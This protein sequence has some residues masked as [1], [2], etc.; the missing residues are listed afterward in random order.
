MAGKIIAGVAGVLIGAAAVGVAWATTPH[1]YIACSLKGGGIMAMD[2]IEKVER[3]R[4]HLEVS[5]KGFPK[6]YRQPLSNISMCL[7]GGT[8]MINA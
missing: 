8:A 6:P 2:G 7:D 3:T 5:R 4:T 1:H